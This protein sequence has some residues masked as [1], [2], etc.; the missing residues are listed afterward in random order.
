MI[1][2]WSFLNTEGDLREEIVSIPAIRLEM[3]RIPEIGAFFLPHSFC[4]NHAFV[5]QLGV[6]FMMI[7]PSAKWEGAHVPYTNY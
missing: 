7:S 3:E 1:Q 6:H 5:G 4:E 2:E